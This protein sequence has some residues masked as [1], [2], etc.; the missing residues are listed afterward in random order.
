MRCQVQIYTPTLAHCTSLKPEAAC[1]GF[2][3]VPAHTGYIPPHMLIYL[4]CLSERLFPQRERWGL[5]RFTHVF[6]MKLILE[7]AHTS[8]DRK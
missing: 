6:E 3:S 1:S 8:S 7:R 2:I 4:S 5:T